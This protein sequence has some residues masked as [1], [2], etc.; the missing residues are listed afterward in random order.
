MLKGMR[1]IGREIGGV[2]ET[3]DEEMVC[4]GVGTGAHE[5][6]YKEATQNGIWTLNQR[7]ERSKVSGHLSSYLGVNSS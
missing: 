6:G 1:W 5:G 4:T 3:G 7:K 2:R